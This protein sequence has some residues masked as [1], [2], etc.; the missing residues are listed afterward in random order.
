MH[1]Q[2]RRRTRL[3]KRRR[4]GLGHSAGLMLRT[5]SRPLVPKARR[6]GS[7]AGRASGHGTRRAVSPVSSVPAW[8]S[9]AGLQGQAQLTR[10]GRACIPRSIPQG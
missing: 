3:E 10:R 6:R 4:E 1:T 9:V 8:G 2:A 5:P 7:G